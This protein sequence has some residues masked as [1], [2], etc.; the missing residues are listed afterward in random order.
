MAGE[1]KEVVGVRGARLGPPAA[2]CCRRCVARIHKQ[3]K[4]NPNNFFGRARSNVPTCPQT[5]SQEVSKSSEDQFRPV[6]HGKSLLA[7]KHL[8]SAALQ[9]VA[10]VARCSCIVGLMVFIQRKSTFLAP[11][12]CAGRIYVCVFLCV[13]QCFICFERSHVFRVG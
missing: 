6:H 2:N 1:E 8:L 10:E 4:K 12:L 3:T 9:T 13:Q 11:Q 7:V 5:T